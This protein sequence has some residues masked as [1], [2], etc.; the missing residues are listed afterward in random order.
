MIGV[1]CRF[2]KYSHAVTCDV[3]KMFHQFIVREEDRDYLRFLWWPNGD[4]SQYPKEYRM[5]VHLF[6]ETSS[7]G[8]ASYGLRHMAN[9]DKEIYPSAAQFIMHNFYGLTSLDSF[10][11]AVRLVNGAREI[12]KRG[13]LRLHKFISN[14]CAVI[15]S[16]PESERAADVKL[17]IPS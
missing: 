13:G 15:E 1:L 17:D 10:D 7:P 9:E 5:K 6:G 3:K 8:C 16:I 2:R 11:E 4:V 14:D 12:C